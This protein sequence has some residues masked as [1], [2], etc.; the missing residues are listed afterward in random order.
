[1]KPTD[2]FI[3]GYR[4]RSI[5]SSL[6][7][8]R[9]WSPVSHVAT[10][11]GAGNVIEAWHPGGVRFNQS[12]HQG[13]THRTRIDLYAPAFS[14]AQQAA[15]WNFQLDQTGRKYD[16][17]GIFGFITRRDRAHSSRKWFCSELVHAASVH[18]G[19]PLLRS[20]PSHR[21]YPGML[22]ASPILTHIGHIVVNA[23]LGKTPDAAFPSI[24]KSI[25]TESAP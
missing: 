6:I 7:R 11:N 13:H 9:T 24:A 10:I 8:F 3:G 25:R 18:V 21:V 14:A 23:R 4:G 12:F 16:F 1:M 20:I 22:V 15:F 2:I 19:A 5:I 17:R